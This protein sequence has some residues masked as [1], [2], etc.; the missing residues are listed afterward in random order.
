MESAVDPRQFCDR[1]LDCAQKLGASY[2]D[3]R[4][5]RRDGESIWLRTGKV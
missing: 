2:A 1:V 3:V 4:I 5:V